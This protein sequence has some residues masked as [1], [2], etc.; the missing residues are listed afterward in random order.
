MDVPLM[1]QRGGCGDGAVCL[2]LAQ[3]VWL[4]RQQ[5]QNGD[6]WMPCQG[7]L[8]N[9]ARPWVCSAAMGHSSGGGTEIEEPGAPGTDSRPPPFPPAGALEAFL[10]LPGNY[11]LLWPSNPISCPFHIPLSL[12]TSPLP[13]IKGGLAPLCIHP[14]GAQRVFVALNRSSCCLTGPLRARPSWGRQVRFALWKS[15]ASGEALHISARRQR[16]HSEKGPPGE[17]MSPHHWRWPSGGCMAI[18][19]NV[20]EGNQ[21]SEFPRETTGSQRD[22][23]ETML[24]LLTHDLRLLHCLS[25]RQRAARADSQSPGLNPRHLLQSVGLWVNVLTPCTPE[26]FSTQLTNRTQEKSRVFCH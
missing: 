26:A 9:N 21:G 10:S 20:R 16:A 1:I 17:V 8:L 22:S 7:S 12:P 14:M 13:S 15:G 5:R 11:L 18:I 19:S 6:Q 3:A 24:F 4:S 25:E 23:P 2:S